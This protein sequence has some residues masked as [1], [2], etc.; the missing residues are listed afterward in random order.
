MLIPLSLGI[1]ASVVSAG[2]SERKNVLWLVSDDLRPQLNVS[3]GQSFM[4]T[5]SL[6]RFAQDALVFD[7][8]YTNF[9]ICSASRNSFMTGRLPDKTRTWNFINHVSEQPPHH[10]IPFARHDPC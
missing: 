6:D 5:P 10:P 7:N 9:A 3:Y 1:A 2:H 4:H 8:A